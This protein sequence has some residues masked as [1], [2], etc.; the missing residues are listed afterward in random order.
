LFSLS[1]RLTCN[2][3]YSACFVLCN[4]AGPS[5]DEQ[6]VVASVFVSRFFSF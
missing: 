4:V 3:P 1:P 5:P 6:D 2:F